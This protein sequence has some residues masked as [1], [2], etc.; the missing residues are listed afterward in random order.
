MLNSLVS[1]YLC[2][3][4]STPTILLIT[5]VQYYYL[6]QSITNIFHS[7]ILLFTALHCYFAYSW[8]F[9]ITK[10]LSYKSNIS[11]ILRMS[12]LSL[13]CISYLYIFIIH[14]HCRCD[15]VVKIQ[16][17]RILKACQFIMYWS[18]QTCWASF[19]FGRFFVICVG[20]VFY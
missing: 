13:K 7:A 11:Y 8:V 4:S 20:I 5:T 1:I 19:T 12:Y 6:W 14:M 10:V 16:T 3:S 9:L 15:A 2:S 17:K 18:S